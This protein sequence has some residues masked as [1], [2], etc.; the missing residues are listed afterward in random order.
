MSNKKIIKYYLS[1][2][3]TYTI[4]SETD[5]NHKYFIIRVNELPGICTVFSCETHQEK[6]TE[7]QGC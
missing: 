4:E 1:L 6:F 5:G 7:F 2:D 3:W